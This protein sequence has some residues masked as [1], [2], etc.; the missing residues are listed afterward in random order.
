M[1]SNPRKD[2]IVP[3]LHRVF[4]PFGLQRPNHDP[5]ITRLPQTIGGGDGTS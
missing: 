4:T 5:K 1:E 3:A 2:T